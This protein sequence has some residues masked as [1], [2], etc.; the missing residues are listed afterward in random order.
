MVVLK[1]FS[2]ISGISIEKIEREM[3]TPYTWKWLL[4]KVEVI[5]LFTKT[6]HFKMWKCCKY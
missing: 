5:N 6:I 3:D 1:I 2:E 4:L